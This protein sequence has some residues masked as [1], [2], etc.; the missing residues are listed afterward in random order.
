MWLSKS[1]ALRQSA[2]R[3]GAAA[4]MGTTTIGGGS[5]SVMTRG[6][7]RDLS[8]FSPSGVIWQPKAGDTVLVIK[9][10]A[11]GQEQCI[12]AADTAGAAPEDLV[13]GELYLHSSRDTFI[14]LRADGSIAVKGN[15]S[16]EGDG[17]IKGSINLTGD[18]E[19]TGVVTVNGTLSVNGNLIINGQPYR[20]CSCV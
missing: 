12:I 6:E 4:D 14:F 18:V 10:G 15:L 11:G 16:A 8:V 9:G 17:T 20:P 13:P 19:L 1:I 7:Q 5:A 3:E 2:A